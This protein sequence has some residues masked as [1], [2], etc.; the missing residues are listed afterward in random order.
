MFLFRNDLVALDDVLLVYLLEHHLIAVSA[1]LKYWLG[2]C[3]ALGAQVLRCLGFGVGSSQLLQ[4]DHLIGV[5]SVLP[6]LSN[7]V[8]QIW[9]K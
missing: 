3:K 1:L 8:G 2:L 4:M 5:L 7:L 6:F 9:Q